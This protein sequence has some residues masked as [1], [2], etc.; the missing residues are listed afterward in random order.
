MVNEVKKPQEQRQLEA[1]GKFD[2]KKS[3]E[4]EGI[5]MLPSAFCFHFLF[6]F[7]FCKSWKTQEGK[8]TVAQTNF[9]INK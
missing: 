1:D 8:C 6:C 4:K 2:Q 9:W 5:K 3:E 7:L